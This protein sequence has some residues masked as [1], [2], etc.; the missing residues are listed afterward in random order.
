MIKYKSKKTK[1]KNW[2]YM[3]RE[4][5]RRY[6]SAKITSGCYEKGTPTIQQ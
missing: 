6:Y 3:H 1:F 5:W 4:I 2:N